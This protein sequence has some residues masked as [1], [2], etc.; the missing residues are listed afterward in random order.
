M[1]SVNST[2]I[3]GPADSTVRVTSPAPCTVFLDGNTPGR[4]I[5]VKNFSASGIAITIQDYSG[6]TVDLGSYIQFG[7]YGTAATF[8]YDQTLTD[9]SIS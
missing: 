7:Q 1:A 5:T 8:T 2:Y 4:M 6:G 3:T 9:W